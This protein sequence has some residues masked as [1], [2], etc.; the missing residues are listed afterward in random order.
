MYTSY[1]IYVLSIKYI[2]YTEENDAELFETIDKK[3]RM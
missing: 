1:L 3:N 2:T